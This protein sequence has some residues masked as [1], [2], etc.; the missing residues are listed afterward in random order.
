[1]DA[2]GGDPDHAD[3][4]GTELGMLTLDRWPKYV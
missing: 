4:G 2:I 3:D 1:M